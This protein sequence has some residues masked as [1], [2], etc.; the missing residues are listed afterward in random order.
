M[1]EAQEISE[2]DNPLQESYNEKIRVVNGGPIGGTEGGLRADIF[3]H[4]DPEY[5]EMPCICD[6]PDHAQDI[7]L[8]EIMQQ[9][10]DILNA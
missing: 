5:D 3:D 10:K 8:D 4:D 2:Q 7:L 6:L 9:D 1:R